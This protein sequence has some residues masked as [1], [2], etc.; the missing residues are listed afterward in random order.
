[1]YEYKAQVLKVIDGD[2]VD[3]SI[4]LGFM[5]CLRQRVRL[6]GINCPETR[7]KNKK[8]KAQGLISKRWVESELLNKEVVIQTRLEESKNEYDSFGRV[9][10][11]IFYEGININEE[12]VTLGLAERYLK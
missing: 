1:M 11:I 6:Y 8:E 2:T 12:M 5:I 10:A 3:V 4:D 7:T 9:L